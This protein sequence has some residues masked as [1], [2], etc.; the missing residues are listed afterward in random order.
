M[1]TLTRLRGS[2]PAFGHEQAPAPAAAFEFV[3]GRPS[4]QLWASESVTVKWTV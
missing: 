3:G 1:G 4:M 2:R